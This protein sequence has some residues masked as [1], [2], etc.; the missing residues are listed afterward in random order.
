VSWSDFLGLTNPAFR[1]LAQSI[2]R[3][4]DEGT[5]FQGYFEDGEN[6]VRF[7]PGTYLLRNATRQVKDVALG[8]VPYCDLKLLTNDF[9]TL[10]PDTK[11]AKELLETSCHDRDGSPYRFHFVADYAIGDSALNNTARKCLETLGT[12]R[13]VNTQVFLWNSKTS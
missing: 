3:S 4:K 12:E 7:V 5:K 9:P 8:T 1:R 13:C 11:A 2:V 10:L 6:E